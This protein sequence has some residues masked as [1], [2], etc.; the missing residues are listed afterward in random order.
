MRDRRRP[1]GGG[2][3]GR[4]SRSRPGPGRECDRAR[5]ISGSGPSVTTATATARRRACRPSPSSNEPRRHDDGGAARRGP[6]AGR[7]AWARSLRCRA[8]FGFVRVLVVAAVLGTTFLGNAFQAANS[9]SNVV[10]ELVAAGALSAVLVPTFVHLLE[11]GDDAEADRLAERTAWGSPSLVLG[12]LTRRRHRSRRR[13]LA[14]LL[15]IG[16][17]RRRDRRRTARARDVPAALVPAA[18]RAVRVGHGRDRAAVRAPAVRDHRRRADRQHRRDGRRRSSCSASSPARSRRC[19]SRSRERLLL[20]VAGTGGVLAFVGVLCRRGAGERILAATALARARS[21]ARRGCCGSPA[22]AR[23]CNANAGLLLGA[24]IVVGGSVAGGV[25]AYQVAFVFFLAPYAIL[26]QPIHTAILP[27]LAV[28]VGARRHARVR[29]DGSRPRSTAWPC[30][31]S[32][33]RPRSSRSRSRRCASSCS[34]GRQATASSCSPP[35]SPRSPSVCTRTACSSCSP[36][37]YYALDDSRTPAFA[38]IASALVGVATMIGVAAVTHG[39]ARVAALGIGHSVAYALGASFLGVGLARRVGPRAVPAPRRRRRRGYSCRAGAARVACDARAR[40]GNPAR[41]LGDT[42]GAGG[43]RSRR[44][45]R[46]WRAGGC[47]RRPR[48]VPEHERWHPAG[49]RGGRSLPVWAPAS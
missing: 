33:C 48:S 26:A 35:G 38:A 4:R 27:E 17:D 24:A 12:S 46:R 45:M 11:R 25:V 8:A 1:G 2:L 3:D 21:R 18:D 36:A 6:S 49:V 9:V 14:R 20:A 29:R 44:P 16:V 23:C 10:F 41:D 5:R 19:G 31:S 37:A 7:R 15:T 28:D 32:R 13:L 22:G 30:S 42:R 43:A 39:S 40:S 47:N 34:G